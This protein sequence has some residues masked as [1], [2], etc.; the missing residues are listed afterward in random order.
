MRREVGLTGGAEWGQNTSYTSSATLSRPPSLPSEAQQ[1]SVHCFL[2]SLGLA[3]LSFWAACDFQGAYLSPPPPPR[4]GS[5]L[6]LS[7]PETRLR[8]S[9]QGLSWLGTE[10]GLPE[11]DSRASL[12]GAGSPGG[13]RAWESGP[14]GSWEN[15]RELQSWGEGL[16]EGDRE[17]WRL[18]ECGPPSGSGVI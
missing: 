1:L 6:R 12:D 17:K 2:A 10:E 3:F 7:L 11:E 18:K 9:H 13:P 8:G 5:I 15:R 4:L 14:Q 16:E